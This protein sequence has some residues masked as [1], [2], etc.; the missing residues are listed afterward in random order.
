MKQ[1]KLEQQEKLAR[2]RMGKKELK[3]KKRIRAATRGG[4]RQRGDDE[5]C[6]GRAKRTRR[7]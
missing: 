5:L 7:A 3:K 2:A 6:E 4:K 1:R